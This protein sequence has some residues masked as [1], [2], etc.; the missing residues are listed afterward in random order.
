MLEIFYYCVYVIIGFF[1]LRF[2]FWEIPKFFDSY[3]L[4]VLTAVLGVSVLIGI[5]LLSDKYGIPLFLLLLPAIFIGVKVFTAISS[6]K[7]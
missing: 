7:N 2:I 1:V 6:K 3:W 4:G 5:G